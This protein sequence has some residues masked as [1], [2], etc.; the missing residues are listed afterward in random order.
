MVDRNRD[1]RLPECKKEREREGWKR[2]WEWERERLESV[3]CIF[4]VWE[5]DDGQTPVGQQ[6][7]IEFLF[8]NIFLKKRERWGLAVGSLFF[9]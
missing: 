9:W 3:E 5:G 7:C 2:E 8:L 4:E 6:Q 1:R